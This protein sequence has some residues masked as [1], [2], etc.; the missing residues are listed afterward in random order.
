MSEVNVGE[1]RQFRSTLQGEDGEGILVR[2]YTDQHVDVIEDLGEAESVD[3]GPGER[4]FRV[5]ADDGTTFAAWESELIPH[6]TNVYVLPNGE[7]VSDP[8]FAFRDGEVEA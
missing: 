2:R 4:L 8:E 5:R 6:G 1:R 3:D 7:Y